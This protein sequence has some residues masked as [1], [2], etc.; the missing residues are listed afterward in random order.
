MP[1]AQ[2]M[3]VL[4]ALAAQPA[5]WR[6]GYELSSETGLKSG[7][8]YPILMRLAERG[9]LDAGWE[10]TPPAGRPARHLYR[11]TEAGLDLVA[12]AEPD[13][14]TQRTAPRLSGRPQLDGA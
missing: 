2:A 14:T 3:K 4:R 8:L 13:Q 1:S 6:Y 11:P 12:A 7:S 5:R 9:Y 10:R